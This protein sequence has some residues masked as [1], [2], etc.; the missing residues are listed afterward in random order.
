MGRARAPSHGR[1]SRLRHLRPASAAQ[2]PK[3]ADHD[4]RRILRGAAGGALLG[5]QG[6]IQ[7]LLLNR[8]EE[9]QPWH[10]LNDAVCSL[11]HAVNAFGDLYIRQEIKPYFHGREA[12]MAV[13]TIS[14]PPMA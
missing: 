8:S 6:T 14:A 13:Q 5:R 9:R 3:P 12:V 1:S 10:Q 11:I 4:L 2:P 7:G